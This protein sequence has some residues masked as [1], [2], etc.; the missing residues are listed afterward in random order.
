ML[1]LLGLLKPLQS[2]NDA[3]GWLGRSISVIALALMVGVILLQV[4][5]RYVLNNA[6]PWPDEAARFCMLWLTGLMAPVAL[7]QGGF[8]AIDTLSTF[9]P[10]RGIAI[11][12]IILFVISLLVLTVAVE[13]GWNHV[14]TGLLFASASL[15]LPLHLIG[16]KAVKIKLA[17]MYMSLFTS[18]CLMILVNVEMIIRQIV[19]LVRQEHH[20]RPIPILDEQEA[21]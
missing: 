16:L 13:L 2:F 9:L 4:F 7:R 3:A 10:R 17:W 19:I 8:V 18:A 14:N 5:C 15:K 1:L 6:L 21:K 20:L 11:L 12:A